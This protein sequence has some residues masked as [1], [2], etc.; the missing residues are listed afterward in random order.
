M[1]NKIIKQS[2]SGYIL[3]YLFVFILVSLF[4]TFSFYLSRESIAE[5]VGGPN[6]DSEWII[7]SI[8]I[9]FLAIPIIIVFIMLSIYNKPLIKFTDK[10]LIIEA[11]NKNNY[12]KL[13]KARGLDWETRMMVNIQKFHNNVEYY[14]IQYEGLIK[15]PYK[16]IYEITF[17][18]NYLTNI[19]RRCRKKNLGSF[20]YGPTKILY[21]DGSEI[22]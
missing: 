7:L 12:K 15:I 9:S 5:K 2:N 17:T 13:K 10:D 22:N 18:K 6:P 16:E 14:L 21:F 20:Y 1:K 11:L 19:F 3:F 8:F 4:F